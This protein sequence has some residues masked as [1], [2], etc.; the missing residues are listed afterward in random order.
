MYLR[1]AFQIYGYERADGIGRSG[2]I[3]VQG[4]I[5]G[6]CAAFLPVI[7]CAGVLYLLVS[8]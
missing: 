5:R 3:V 8:S 6:I 2:D 4:F 1:F 7:V